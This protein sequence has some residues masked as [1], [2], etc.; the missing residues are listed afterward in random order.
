MFA[1]L[2][3]AGRLRVHRSAETSTAGLASEERCF[4]V[5]SES[6]LNLGLGLLPGER[7]RW[8]LLRTPIT[9]P[10]IHA[11]DQTICDGVD[12]PNLAI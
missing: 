3:K 12:M 5:L 1:D 8:G 6:P 4:S 11:L 10:N 9:F 2:F 7:R